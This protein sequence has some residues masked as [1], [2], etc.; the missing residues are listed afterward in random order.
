MPE[1]Q[2]SLDEP[3]SP[4][5]T[6]LN[7]STSGDSSRPCLGHQE[8]IMNTEGRGFQNQSGMGETS[9]R[10]CAGSTSHDCQSELCLSGHRSHGHSDKLGLLRVFAYTMRRMKHQPILI[11]RHGVDFKGDHL[12]QKDLSYGAPRVHSETSAVPSAFQNWQL[13]EFTQ[14]SLYP[15]FIKTDKNQVCSHSC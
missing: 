12:T 7:A 3:D 4:R 15:Q 2:P 10:H 11:L 9:T 14:T 1:S 13:P 6:D 5:N 8:K